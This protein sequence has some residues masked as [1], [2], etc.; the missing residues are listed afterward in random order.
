MPARPNR[1]SSIDRLPE[2][3]R[4]LIGQLRQDGRT[5]DEILDK[6]RELDVEVSRSA[7]GRHV[8]S[9]AEI[10][11]DMRRSRDIASAL[12]GQFGAE[13]DDKLA[14]LNM[15]LMHGVI[16]QIMTAA[17]KPGEDGE[18]GGPVTFSAGDAMFLAKALQSLTSASKTD[19]EKTIR[20]REEAEKKARAEAAAAVDRVAKRTEAGL[21]KDTVNA[22]KRE[23][24]GLRD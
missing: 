16:F 8:K 15:E 23:I 14:R 11:A 21:S 3:I 6:L 12:V 24:L 13:P 10:G 20:L 2:P 19:A 9:L 1:P 17:S 18:E 22:I 5:I 7:V 4:A